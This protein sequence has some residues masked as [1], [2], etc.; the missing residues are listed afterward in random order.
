MYPPTHRTSA[1]VIAS[2]AAVGLALQGCAAAGPGSATSESPNGSAIPAIAEKV[3]DKFSQV[4]YVLDATYPPLSYQDAS[5]KMTGVEFDLGMEVFARAGIDAD[6]QPSAFDAIIPGIQAG[7]YHL[8]AFNDTAKRQ[9]IFDFVDLFQSGTSII[10]PKGNPLSLSIDDLC[11]IRVAVQL[12][13]QQETTVAPSLNDA[14]KADGEKPF[15]V[16]TYGSGNE[17]VL[18]LTSN[19]ADVVLTETISAAYAV[20]ES[21]EKLALTQDEPLDPHPVAL[22][23]MKGTGLAQAL[24]ASLQSMMDDGT[25]ASI[26]AQWKMDSLAIESAT[27]NAGK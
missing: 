5:G 15:E 9:E 11:G 19:R 10:V 20:S 24:Q 25:Y 22:G 27:I 8:S 2:L 26:L 23:M 7:K 16:I 1:I 12:G 18:A 4:V 17:A 3:P 21:P 6:V 14:C 13:S